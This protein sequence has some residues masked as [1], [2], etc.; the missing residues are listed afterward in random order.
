M[1]K[2]LLFLTALFCVTSLYA[3]NNEKCLTN[4]EFFTQADIV[5]EGR[6]LKPVDIYDSKGNDIYNSKDEDC[7]R[8]DAYL[9][10]RMYKGP[11][12]NAGDIIYVVSQG[13]WLGSKDRLDI[14]DYS[15]DLYIE[16]PFLSKH[17]IGAINCQSPGV[18][19]L[20]NSDFPDDKDKN[21]KY[22]TYNKYKFVNRRSIEYAGRVIYDRMYARGDNIAGLDS[23]VFHRREDFY[24]YM[25]QFEGFTVPELPMEEEQLEN[26]EE[27]N[28]IMDAPYD[29]AREESKDTGKNHKKKYRKIHSGRN[30]S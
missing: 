11:T 8:I 7:Y 16:F 22:A 6:F 12:Y 9:V 26:R 13:A 27:Q 23:L 2:N 14:Y 10:H 18:F 19:F 20:V 30:A 3:Q 1:K 24:N 21:S 29:K 4:E 5:F 15:N 25:K 28:T 17:G